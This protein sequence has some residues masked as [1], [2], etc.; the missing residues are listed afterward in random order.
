MTTKVYVCH[1]ELD[2][3]FDFIIYDSMDKVLAHFEYAIDVIGMTE[4]DLRKEG[5]IIEKEIE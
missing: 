1:N 5:H 3:P 4:G 2:D